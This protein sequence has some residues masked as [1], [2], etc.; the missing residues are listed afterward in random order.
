MTLATL[1]QVNAGMA[2]DLL[3]AWPR[4]GN[5]KAFMVL[6]MGYRRGQEDLYLSRQREN[7]QIGK[8][9]SVRGI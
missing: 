7:L 3:T 1:A 5:Q 8:V 4:S 2:V 9:K 6:G